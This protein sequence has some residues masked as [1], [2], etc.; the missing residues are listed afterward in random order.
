MSHKFS[1]ALRYVGT[2]ADFV[3]FPTS[4]GVDPASSANLP[5]TRTSTRPPFARDEFCEK[6]GLA[7]EDQ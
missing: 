2:G 4:Q 5:E 1:T 3:G 6:C 7:G